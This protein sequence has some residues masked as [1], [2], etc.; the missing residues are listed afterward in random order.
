MWKPSFIGLAVA[1]VLAA[2]PRTQLLESQ[3]TQ[4][5]PPPNP[6]HEVVVTASR[7]ETPARE[8]ASS[9]TVV[10]GADLDRTR[11][12]NVLEA[13]RDAVGLSVN[14]NGGPGSASSILLR[15][16][17]S[18]HVLVMLDGVE[19]N[20]PMNPSRSFDFAHLGLD[21][22]DRVEVLRGPQSTLYG[23]DALGGVI[24]ILTRRGRGRPSLSLTTQGGSYGTLSNGLDFGGSAGVF[25]YSLGLSQFSTKGFSAASSAF[26]GNAEKDA[27][28]NLSLA[29]RMG[30]ALPGGIEA[31]LIVRAVSAKT[32]LDN[33]GGPNGDD[34]NSTQFYDS[35]FLRG[36]ARALLA[37][38]RWE[39]RLGLSYVGSTRDHENPVDSLH[40]FDSEKGTYRSGRAAVD[41]QNNLFL[42]PS[43]TLTFGI[44]LAREQGE[45]QYASWSAYGEYDSPF[46]RRTADQAGIYLQDQ[47]RIDG[48]FF[49]TV[50]ARLDRHSR[51]G[52][53]LTYRI[54][55]AYFIE[56]TQTRIRATLGTGFKSP[57]LYQLYAPGTFWGP[58]GNAA[59]KPEE[60]LGWDAGIEQMF[61]GGALKAGLTYFRN[62]FR[63]LIDFDFIRGYI[64]IGRA[65][66]RG[67][68]IYAEAIS[69]DGILGRLAYTSLDARDLDTGAAL[70]RRPNA[71]LSARVDVPFL[72][73]F[74][75]GVSAAWTGAR[76]DK[77]FTGWEARDVVLAPY[78]LLDASLSCVLG[79]AARLFVRLDNVLDARYETVYGYGTA[80]FSVYGGIKLGLIR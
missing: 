33:F 70:L 17:N 22:V 15:G 55:P 60:S 4:S 65:R 1:A 6:R 9:V 28:R 48:R 80:R 63:N 42:S 34:P 21:N 64:N 18:E 40:P 38:G 57:S 36:Q 53:A 52:T 30:L 49:A 11:V 41:W 29:G 66:T 73:R 8:I 51:S 32:S 7:L 2:A 24:N 12:A 56:A 45:S 78:V 16:S 37:G 68:E 50:G 3:K 39:Q 10:A 59:L 5:P 20:D 72:R 13:L 67:V 43:H 25:N 69:A 27:Y 74:T 26:A 76:H 19:L 23:S 58:I 79:P 71:R 75:A 44:D 54:A 77:D 31:D 14:A 61:L 46:P 35:L 62:D 47:L